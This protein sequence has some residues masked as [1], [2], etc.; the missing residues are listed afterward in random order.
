MC[1]YTGWSSQRPQTYLLLLLLLFFVICWI[2]CLDDKKTYMNAHEMF[3]YDILPF[4]VRLEEKPPFRSRT[5]TYLLAIG[6][7]FSGSFV[8]ILLS[9]ASKNR[10]V[11]S[12]VFY[13]GFRLSYVFIF[14]EKPIDCVAFSFRSCSFVQRCSFPFFLE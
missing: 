11:C 12:F 3:R 10:F 4:C 13:Q 9:F 14:S 8:R 5:R 2:S 6:L 1:V 7:L